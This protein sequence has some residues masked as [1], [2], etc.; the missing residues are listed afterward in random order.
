MEYHA[1]LLELP[2]RLEHIQIQYGQQI[3][4]GAKQTEFSRQ[5][6]YS[7]PVIQNNNGIDAAL[8]SLRQA[9]TT[10][11]GTSSSNNCLGTIS[12]VLRTFFLSRPVQCTTEARTVS[13]VCKSWR[14]GYTHPKGLKFRRRG[15]IGD[16][17]VGVWKCA[18]FYVRIPDST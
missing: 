5:F 10:T 4:V 17:N 3:A 6:Y 16:G 8:K 15:K 1:L 13:P 7:N 9:T 2:H 12:Y 18:P 11:T 14:Q